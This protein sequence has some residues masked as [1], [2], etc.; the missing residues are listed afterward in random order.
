MG[1][2]GINELVNAF[3]A[4]S[5]TSDKVK[6]L[7]VGPYEQKLDPLKKET[8]IEIESNSKIITTGFVK[9]VR[10]YFAVSDALAFPS[11][12]EGFLM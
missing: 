10:P 2:K 1:D 6:L 8:L 12:R 7:L 4:I 5:K 3:S 11:Y 9:D